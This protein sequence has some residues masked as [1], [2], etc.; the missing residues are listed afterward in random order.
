VREWN[1][2]LARESEDFNAG[3]GVKERVAKHED[4]SRG[5]CVSGDESI[6]Q[7]Q[8]TWSGISQTDRGQAGF[9]VHGQEGVRWKAP[10]EYR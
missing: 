5:V 2:V 1:S 7:G 6:G 8:T 3:N 9:G 4:E 10:G